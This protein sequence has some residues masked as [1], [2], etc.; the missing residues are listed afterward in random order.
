MHFKDICI[1]L[2]KLAIENE[3]GSDEFAKIDN[4]QDT[5]LNREWKKKHAHLKTVHYIDKV[6]TGTHWAG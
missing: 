1:K 5:R 3:N 2:T 4:D 6:D